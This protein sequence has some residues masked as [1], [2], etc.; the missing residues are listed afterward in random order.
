ML[1]SIGVPELLV[2]VLVVVTLGVLMFT[3]ALAVIFL[4]KVTGIAD[5][6][7]AIRRVWKPSEGR[8]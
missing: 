4:L 7:P 6:G 2:I 1:R 3:F 8:R 5:L